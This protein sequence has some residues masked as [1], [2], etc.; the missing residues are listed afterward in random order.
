MVDCNGQPVGY[1]R[2]EVLERLK[3]LLDQGRRMITVVGPPGVGKTHLLRRFA[4]CV[5]APY[6]DLSTAESAVQLRRAVVRSLELSPETSEQ[7]EDVVGEAQEALVAREQSLLVV[8]GVDEAGVLGEEFVENLVKRIESSQVVC[9]VRKRLQIGDEQLLRLPPLDVPPFDA[10]PEQIQRTGAGRMFV[11]EMRRVWPGFE[12]DEGNAGD[13]AALLERLDGLPYAIRLAAART[14]LYGI[15]ELYDRLEDS[16]RIL[17]DRASDREQN[18]LDDVIALSWKRLDPPVRR[19]LSALSLLPDDFDRRAAQAVIGEDDAIEILGELTDASL[20]VV[21]PRAN[22]R[23]FRVLTTIRRFAVSRMDDGDRRTAQDRIGDYY[24]ELATRLVA[25]LHTSRGA[26]ALEK[27]DRERT[28]LEKM[29]DDPQ[30]HGLTADDEVECLLA[31]NMVYILRGGPRGWPERLKRRRGRLQT[32]GADPRRLAMLRMRSMFWNQAP[33]RIEEMTAAIEEILE[34]AREEDDRRLELRALMYSGHMRLG[35]RAREWIAEAN[36]LAETMELEPA[37]ECRLWMCSG[38]VAAMDGNT[39]ETRRLWRR[40][41]RRSREV[42]DQWVEGVMLHL[43]GDLDIGRSFDRATTQLEQAADHYAEVGLPSNE[44]AARLAQV[45]AMVRYGEHEGLEPLLGRCDALA[46]RQGALLART[47]VA[48]LRG[49]YLAETGEFD[50][51]RDALREAGA[52]AKSAESRRM[53]LQGALALA[54]VEFVAR[55]PEAANAVLDRLRSAPEDD[56][57][58]SPFLRARRLGV[59][60]SVAAAIGDEQRARTLFE[61][62]DGLRSVREQSV[63]DT[64]SSV[65]R[66]HLEY[67]PESID[68]FASLEEL[69]RSE[70]AAHSNWARMAISTAEARVD[71]RDRR[72]L[73]ELE[74]NGEA[75][76]VVERRRWFRTPNGSWCDLSIRGV[77]WRF[78]VALARRR[79]DYQQG[80]DSADVVSDDELVERVW[81]DQ[82]LTVDAASN[83]LYVTV[84]SLR[85]CGLDDESIERTDDGYRLD[86]SVQW[87]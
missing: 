47:R 62:I 35:D 18:P 85:D 44:R 6:V 21:E 15:A 81:P 49:E 78:F 79:R 51:A 37:L 45:E 71:K 2:D 43:L 70:A 34:V 25:R 23:R 52:M 86:T 41:L 13:V 4:E 73:E 9:A 69:K 32:S 42:G 27:L 50:R 40:A 5:D 33:R 22:T 56:E 80:E 58:R 48:L 29:I 11:D 36:Q 16:N 65:A 63:L 39:E 31:L 67:D 82:K 3:R 53:E 24:A 66:W 57:K 64:I 28:H 38:H 55:G 74:E 26:E 7:T 20:V 77:P 68:S 54:S 60:A 75:V 19:G 83:R 72:L 59:E 46:R 12:I 17:T 1:G 30:S 8:D 76:V 14:D 84:N 61:R 10:A 87:I